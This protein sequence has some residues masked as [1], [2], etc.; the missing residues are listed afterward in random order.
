MPSVGADVS[1][2]SPIYLP[3]SVVALHAQAAHFTSS[4]FIRRY[5]PNTN[6]WSDV[7]RPP[8][9]GFMLQLTP[10]QSSSGAVLWFVGLTANGEETLFRYVV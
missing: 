2:P 4:Q 10:V 3:S 5:D 7:T 1:R 6:S 9:P 8:T